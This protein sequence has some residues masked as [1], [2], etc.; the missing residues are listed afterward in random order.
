MSIGLRDKIEAA[1]LRQ[2]KKRASQFADNKVIGI[3]T[4]EKI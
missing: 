3:K 1:L 2:P 4:D